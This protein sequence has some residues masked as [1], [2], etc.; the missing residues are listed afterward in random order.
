ML[1][2]LVEPALCEPPRLIASGSIAADALD[3]LGETVGGIGSGLVYDAHEKVYL[4]VSDRGPGDGM[5]DYRPRFHRLR[6]SQAP[7]DP[8]KLTIEIL[9]TVL[10]RSPEGKEMTGLRPDGAEGPL[11]RL[12]DGRI[13]IDPEGIALA[14]DGTVYISDEYGPM[15]YQFKRDGTMVRSITPPPNYLPRNA[16]G[17]VDFSSEDVV[18]GRATNRGFEGLAVS[19]DGK[20]ATLILQSGLSQDGG[21]DAHLTRILVVDLTSEKAVAEYAYRMSDAEE[22]SA[23]LNLKKKKRVKQNDLGISELTY[24]E[25]GRFVALERDNHGAN[26]SENPKQA[27]YKCL[28]E[29]DVRQATNLLSLSGKPDGQAPG[30]Q[31]FHPLIPTEQMRPV[32]KR[33]L[34][35]FAPPRETEEALRFASKWEGIAFGPAD[36]RGRR[37]V[38]IASDNDYLNPILRLREKDVAFDR[39][40]KAVPTTFLMYELELP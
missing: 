31:E 24:L 25:E 1:F 38:V 23:N 19:P 12:R 36:E 10:L 16:K 29:I 35:N 33:L 11:P 14:P 27:A 4:A 9:E 8:T 26:G 7:G 40:K 32:E 37:K 30:S 2:W 20:L 39:A 6:I 28:F 21:R 22:I 5:I 13:C 15:L 17:T 34:L 3:R 18:A